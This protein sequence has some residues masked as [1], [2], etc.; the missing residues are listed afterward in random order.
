MTNVWVI[1]HQLQVYYTIYC[2]TYPVK[3]TNIFFTSESRVNQGDHV[4]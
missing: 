1:S 4:H 3:I 2:N